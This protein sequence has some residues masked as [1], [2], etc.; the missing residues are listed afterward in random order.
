MMNNPYTNRRTIKNPQE[1]YGREREVRRIYSRLSSSHPQ[2]ISIIGERKIGKSSL[3]Y[4]IS[5]DDIRKKWLKD[6]ESYL[7]LL[8]DLQERN[9]EISFSTFFQFI[10][11]RLAERLDSSLVPSSLIESVETEA[12]CYETFKNIV[13]N[14]EKQGYKLTLLPTTT[15]AHTLPPLAQSFKS[16]AATQIF[17]SRRSSTSLHRCH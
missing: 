4:F 10:F 9:G 11:K 5:H 17:P 7:L 14:I 1:F 16:S 13:S 6:A 3:L 8:L 2:C 15:N 12:E